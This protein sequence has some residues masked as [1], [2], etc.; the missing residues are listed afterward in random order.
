MQEVSR[1]QDIHYGWIKRYAALE[2]LKEDEKT[3]KKEEQSYLSYRYSKQNNCD[4]SKLN[5]TDFETAIFMAYQ[6]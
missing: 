6:F 5:L 2:M 4:M 1:L 3:R